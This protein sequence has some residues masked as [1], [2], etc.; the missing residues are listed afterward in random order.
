MMPNMRTAFEEKEKPAM[1]RD[2]IHRRQFLASSAIV[3]ATATSGLTPFSVF[4]KGSSNGLHLSSSEYSWMVF[5]QR[6]NRNFRASL[7]S[8]LKDLIKSD[9]NGLEP[10]ITKPEELDTLAPL[11][12]KNH[13]EIRSLYVNSTLHDSVQVDQSIA[14]LL[15]ISRRA[16]A[17][18]TRI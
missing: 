6:D 17:Q 4:G 15:A 7:E 14:Q 12:K 13:L 2:L 8:S 1:S 10:L 11:L 16:K 9:V 5:Y 18:G 3:S